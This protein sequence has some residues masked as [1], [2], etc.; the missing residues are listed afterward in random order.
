MLFKLSSRNVKR[1]VA[2][3]SI[4][5]LTLV[6]GVCIFYVFNS[7]ES[8]TVMIELSESKREQAKMVTEIMSYVSIFVSFILSFL[9]M[10]ANN[11][12]IKRRSKEFGIYMTLGIG[13]NKIS[14]MLFFETLIIGMLSLIVGMFIGV[15]LSQGLASV[16]A[17]MFDA[18]MSK[19]KFIFSKDA[20]L[21]TI[22][23]FSIMFIV[24]VLLNF[25]VV[26]RYKLIK[27]INNEKRSEKLK[28]NNLILSLVLFILSIICLYVAYKSTLGEKLIYS[29]GGIN[30]KYIILGILGT[31]LFFRALAGFL[32]I[33]IQS[34]KNYYFKNLNTFTLRQLNSKINTHYMSVSVICIMLF[35][36]IGMT[37]AGVGIKKSLEKSIQFKTPF[38]V[39]FEARNGT[40]E[41]LSKSLKQKGFDINKYNKEFVDYNLYSSDITFGKILKNNSNKLSK[42]H[43]D[44]IKDLKIEVIKLSDYNKLKKMKNQEEIVLKDNEILLLSDVTPM[45]SAIEEYLSQNKTINLNN[46]E[47]NLKK[48]Y[49]YEAMY[50]SPMSMNLLTLIVNDKYTENLNTS[51]N[52]LS[53]NCKGNKILPEEKILKDF[54]EF[55][56]V[57]KEIKEIDIYRYGKLESYDYSIGTATVFLYVGIY[58]GM[59]FL[60]ASAA[61]LALSQ[62]SGATESLNRYK[63][64]RKLGVSS[65]MINKS[66]FTQVLLY[67]SLPILLALVHSIFGIKVANDVVKIFGDINVVK[68]NL[69]AI[70]AILIV[71]AI[72]FVTTYNGYKR[73]VNK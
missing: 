61:V 69:F 10:Y 9:I 54:D 44:F 12:I 63:V 11:F 65:E 6:I 25:I 20:C 26:S 29:E 17:K 37:S 60:I 62:L 2:D 13:K 73:I 56:A 51:K 18:N 21:K 4:Y 52:Y 55:E 3:Y 42:Q 72:Y 50:T 36:A 34:S 53:L 19:Y 27:L 30:A 16:T 71:Y 67:F 38:D 46:K 57:S 35:I 28:G 48:H 22:L 40:N 59:V 64:L 45:E 7:L 43:F 68:N 32:I 33:V 66:I 15:F 58:V 39:S 5:F 70:G 31:I 24:V 8:Q 23:Y 47:F 1:S 14:Y 49:E 41:N